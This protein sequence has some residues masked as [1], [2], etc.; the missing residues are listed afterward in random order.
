MKEQ[1]IKY[2]QQRLLSLK[3]R[4]GSDL[5][6]LEEGALRGLGGESSGG[7]SDV[8][9]HLADL[10]MDNY[11]EG[12]ALGLLRNQA[13]ILTE[14]NDALARIEHGTFGQCEQCQQEIS[15]ERLEALPYARYCIRD[16]RQLQG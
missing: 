5:P 1:Q 12:I 14:I 15:R 8:P 11:E 10:G 2:Y 7:L 4:L 16:A 3:R 6:A 13:G 9:T